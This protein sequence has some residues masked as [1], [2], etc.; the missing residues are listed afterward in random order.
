MASAGRPG[1]RVLVLDFDGV[2][3]KSAPEALR[4]ARRTH[5]ALF[6]DLPLPGPEDE[7][8]RRFVRLMPF[9]N[10]AEDYG[11]ALRAIAL[12]IEIPDQAGYDAFKAGLPG[13]M[14]RAFH[15]RFYEE[16]RRFE[17]E[18]PAGWLALLAPYPEVVELLRRRGPER[19]LA[20]ATAKDRHSVGR[21][22]DH[23][24]IADLFPPEL[25]LDKETGV[26]KDLHLRHL[27]ER[28]GVPFEA[29][30]FVDDKV[31]HLERVAPLGVRCV[32]AGWGYNTPR[33]AEIA[34]SRGFAVAGLGDAEAVLFDGRG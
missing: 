21:L 6:P 7:L 3:A 31:H 11:A 16:R 8:A 29:M 15:R 34:R 28:L 32:L 10:R 2:I 20:I 17:E 33:E 22:L 1:D 26:T 23:Y 25:R 9:G 5:E 14:L 30:T 24:G 4:V 27:R 13:E 19:V 18:D 12:G